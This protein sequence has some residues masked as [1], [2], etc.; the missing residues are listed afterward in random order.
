M[1]CQRKNTLTELEES[2][3][4]IGMMK[5]ILTELCNRKFYYIIDE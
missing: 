2:H 1:W 5:M 3:P 4:T